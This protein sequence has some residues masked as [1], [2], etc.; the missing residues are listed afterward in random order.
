MYIAQLMY[1]FQE[2]LVSEK[3]ELSHSSKA[4]SLLHA[5]WCPLQKLYSVQLVCSEREMLCGRGKEVNG[6]GRGQPKEVQL[7]ALGQGVKCLE[8]QF[9]HL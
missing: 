1:F 5:L 3:K 2:L 8:P 9:H 4:H 6:G 7:L